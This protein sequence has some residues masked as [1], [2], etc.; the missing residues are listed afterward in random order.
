MGGSSYTFLVYSAREEWA[1]DKGEGKARYRNI[2]GAKTRC[3]RIT[4]RWGNPVSRG[5]RCL[6]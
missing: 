4:I 6:F 1:R 3:R 2:A 5:F